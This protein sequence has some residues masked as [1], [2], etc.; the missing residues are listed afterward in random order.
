VKIVKYLGFHAKV[1]STIA[2]N[3]LC[4]ANYV[5]IMTYLHYVL[6]AVILTSLGPYAKQCRSC[7]FRTKIDL[8]RRSIYVSM[9]NAILT[10]VGRLRSN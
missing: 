1:Y 2:G 3:I 7:Y 9:Q 5:K 6:S 8:R 4:V 10:L